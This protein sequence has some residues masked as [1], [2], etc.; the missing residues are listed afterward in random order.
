[1]VEL[2]GCFDFFFQELEGL[3]VELWV[4]QAEDLKS[5]FGAI[6]GSSELDLG[7]EA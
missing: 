6:L 7:L 1:M 2:V 3:L 5:V 4:I